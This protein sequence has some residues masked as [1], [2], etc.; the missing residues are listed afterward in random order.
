VHH[1]NRQHCAQT[2]QVD[3]SFGHIVHVLALCMANDRGCG[4]LPALVAQ[5]PS[6]S[7]CIRAVVF[8]LWIL[9]LHCIYT[10]LAVALY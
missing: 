8:V 6:L 5:R 10:R 4:A 1:T 7:P 3:Q 9:V 2:L